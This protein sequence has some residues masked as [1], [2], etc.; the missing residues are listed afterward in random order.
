MQALRPI[1]AMLLT[2]A[3]AGG[4]RYQGYPMWAALLAGVLIGILVPA[5]VQVMI[6]RRKRGD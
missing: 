3:V 1:A 5:I 2:F 4:M 6:M